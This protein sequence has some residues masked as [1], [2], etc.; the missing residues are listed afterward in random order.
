MADTPT[1]LST[2]WQVIKGDPVPFIWAFIALVAA[3]ALGIW[4]AISWAYKS[5]LESA[6]GQI[7]LQDRQLQAY[8]ENLQ[9]ASPDEAKR[10]IEALEHQ[11]KALLPRRLTEEQKRLLTENMKPLGAGRVIIVGYDMAC[12]DGRTYANEFRHLF[13]TS[14]WVVHDMMAGGI[15]NVPQSGLLFGTKGA[16]PN[17]DDESVQRCRN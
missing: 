17:K 6:K 15:S 13:R 4:K 12:S 10:R 5:R 16:I 2:A 8:K 7:E 11:V 9:G 1:N 3:I 14:N